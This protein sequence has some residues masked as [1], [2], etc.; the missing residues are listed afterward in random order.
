MARRRVRSRRTRADG[1]K[2]A[3]VIGTAACRPR[4]WRRLSEADRPPRPARRGPSWGAT[5]CPASVGAGRLRRA[6]AT[7]PPHRPWHS[8]GPRARSPWRARPGSGEGPRASV[9]RRPGVREPPGAGDRGAAARSLAGRVIGFGIGRGGL[10]GGLAIDRGQG[11]TP[12]SVAPDRHLDSTHGSLDPLASDDVGLIKASASRRAIS[13]IRRSCQES[14]TSSRAA[15]AAISSP[16]SASKE[17][18]R[19]P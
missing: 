14:P 10:V 6:T 18:A 9:A 16:A 5:V 7:P 3:P 2:S 12:V 17:R 11:S 1:A 15:R 8:A 13:A 4:R 19:S